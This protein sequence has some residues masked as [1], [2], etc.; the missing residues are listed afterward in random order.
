MD[1]RQAAGT[2]GQLLV[3]GTAS[4]SVLF[5]GVALLTAAGIGIFWAT[6][7]AGC[8]TAATAAWLVVW[9]DRFRAPR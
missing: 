4:V 8:A 2:F 5:S 9:T 3:V 6:V 1:A 7:L